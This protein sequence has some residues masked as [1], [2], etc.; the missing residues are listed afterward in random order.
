MWTTDWGSS[1]LDIT[2]WNMLLSTWVTVNLMGL[3]WVAY[4]SKLIGKMHKHVGF[5]NI[6]LHGARVWSCWTVGVP[7]CKLVSF[8]NISCLQIHSLFSI[9]SSLSSALFATH[10][11]HLWL[12]RLRA[13]D[14]RYVARDVIIRSRVFANIGRYELFL[15]VV[16][17]CSCQQI[18]VLGFK[19]CPPRFGLWAM[20]V[21]SGQL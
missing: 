3:S 1:N 15:A 12:G 4:K 18:F 5:A 17:N 20:W 14:Q 9:L 19:I 21:V 8:G 11:I 7:T 10:V 6:S 16:A 2:L 13:M